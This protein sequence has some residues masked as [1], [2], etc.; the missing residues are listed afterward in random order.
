MHLWLRYDDVM[1]VTIKVIVRPSIIGLDHASTLEDSCMHA[2]NYLWY[3]APRD[4]D[5]NDV[6]SLY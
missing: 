2:S 4:Y 3:T 5:I 1:V 6:N